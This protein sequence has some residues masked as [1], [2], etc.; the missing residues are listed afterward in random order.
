MRREAR[1]RNKIIIGLIVIVV[2]M[3]VGYAAFQTNLNIKGTSKISSNWDIR[4]TNVKEGEKT[5]SAE[6]AKEPSWTELTASMEANLYEKGDAMEYEVTVE[7]KGSLDAKLEEIIT[8]IKSNNEAI[9]ITTSGYTKGEKLYKNTS[10]IVKVKIEYNK[11]YT[12]TAPNTSS[13]VE[14]TLDYGQAEGGTIPDTNDYLVTYDCSSNGGEKCEEYNEY[15]SEGSKIQLSYTANK[16]GWSFAGWN[17]DKNATSGLSSLEMKEADVT[18][19]AIYKKVVNVSYSKGSGVSEIGKAADSCVMYNNATNCQIT[20]PSITASSG[21]TVEGWY[22]GNTKVGS[23]GSKYSITKDTTLTAKGKANSYTLSYEYNGATGGNST[24]SKTVTYKGSY[25]SLPSPSRSYVVSYNYN[26][27]ESGGEITSATS[28]YTFEGWYKEASYKTKVESTSEYNIVGDSTIYAKWKEGEIILPSPSKEGYTFAGWY[29]DESLSNK[30]GE[31][32]GRYSPKRNETLYAKW[33]VKGYTVTYD[34]KSNGGSEASKTSETV[35]Y[36][37]EIDLTVTASK[38]GW[39]FVGWNTDKEATSGLS[40]IKMGASNI[41]LYAIYKKEA[42]TLTAKF[43][44][45]GS[46]LSSSSNLTCTIKEVYNNQVQAS[47]CTVTAPSIT[48]SGY[49]IIGYNTS[50]SSTSNNSSYNITSKA[51]TLTTTNNNSTWYA[52]TSKEVTITFNKNGASTQTNASGTAVSDTTVTRSCTMYNTNASC[53]VT[54]PTIVGSSNTPTVVGYNTSASSTTSS[55]S[56]NTAKA[57]SANATYYAIT[58]KDAK[59]ITVTFNKNGA[60]TQTNASGTAVSDTTVTRSCTIAASYNG[61]AQATTCSVTSPTIVGSSNTPTVVGYNTSASSTTSSWSHNTAKAVSANATYYAI[62]KKDAKTITVTFNKN[63]ASAI[64]STSQSCT[65]AASYNGV[66]QGTSCNVTSPSITAASGFTVLGWNTSSSS[67]SSAWSVSTAKAVSANATYYA[68]TKSSAAYTA[69]FNKN[70]ATSIGSSSLSCYRYN[71]ASSC[72]ITTPSI[73]RSGYTITGWGT[74]ASATTAAVK[75]STSVSLTANVT[76]YAITSKVVTVSFSK[77]ANVSAIGASSGTCTIQNSATSCAVATPSITAN[78]GYTSVG[79]ST[80]NGA[81]SGIAAG[82]NITGLTANATYYANALDKTAPTIS[83]SPSSQSTYVSGGK[84]ITVT[85]ADS[86]SGI[87][88]GQNIYYAWSTSSSTTPSYTSYVTSS[89]AAGAKSTTVTIPA[90]ASSS[91]TGTYYL[92]IK[93][94]TASDVS[95]N[96]SSQVKSSAFKYDNTNPSISVSTSK[97]TSTITVVAT[98]SALS[99]IS[100]YEYSKDNGATWVSN[101][102]SNTYT[103]TGLTHNTS[104]NIKVRVTSG[105]SRQSTSAA[106]ATTTNAISTPTYTS[107]NNGEVLITYPSGCG[108]TYTCSYIKDGGSAVTVSGNTTVYF[109]ANGTLVAKV[110]DGTNTVSAS[111]YSVVRN[112]LYVSS[113]GSDTTGYG[114]KNKPYATIGKAYSSANTTATINIMNNITQTSTVNMNAAKTITLTSYSTTGAINSVIR[115][116]SL[117]AS[118]IN[119]TKGTLTMKNITINGNNVT[120]KDSILTSQSTVTIESGTTI[121]NAK[122]STGDAGGIFIAESGKLTMNGGSVSNNIGGGTG[123]IVVYGTLTINSGDIL[124]NTGGG[125]GGVAVIGNVTIKN[126]NIKGNKATSEASTG[127]MYV[128]GSGSIFNIY[129]GNITGNTGTADTLTQLN[130]IVEQHGDRVITN[131]YTMSPTFSHNSNYYKLVSALD[132]NKAISIQNDS[133]CNVSSGNCNVWL[134]SY[135]GDNTQKWGI[136]LESVIN[137]KTYYKF[138]NVLSSDSC[139]DVFDNATANSTN[140]QQYRCNSTDGQRFYLE[141]AGSGYYYIKHKTSNKCVDISSALTDNGTNI[142]IYTCNQSN[143]QKWK[144]VSVSA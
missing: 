10:K 7:N 37:T 49:S 40:S 127:G 105:V 23:E 130:E 72:N 52:I 41:T 129:G 137:G 119:Q 93:A 106:V 143:A 141:S 68:I 14:V 81:S 100:K 61:T 62:T 71:G 58:K 86:G 84:A 88:A 6:S 65:I 3:S 11:E 8:N 42:V 69:T 78:S 107:T 1:K 2:L 113:S 17:T 24:T 99:G 85:I 48:R 56:H 63:G 15:V 39:S 53:S 9:K 80:T 118:M 98:A 54:S 28:N 64:G 79:W 139:M 92:W 75:V 44:A 120:A 32:G 43:N 38:S 77:G 144:F 31:A 66:A 45:N 13:E 132:N 91:L 135:T 123:G 95:G 20:L 122:N 47:S 34:Y 136:G 67:T 115:G 114:T 126:V 55:W 50:A 5:G 22:N 57:V 90:S 125:V 51:L 25:G 74:S 111:T 121:K 35:N 82:S 116:S 59:T 94:A 109:G 131:D 76:Y 138:Y 128:G 83:I 29:S 101:G 142:Q 97:S 117:T 30:V 103:F 60:A 102:T 89:N 96:T 16:S 140:V 70:G 18:L 12:G 110:S 134:W 73:T 133:N 33:T 104:Y 19:Y 87:K 36:G 46:T 108:S 112:D 124:N 26:G 4:I 27:A 21:Y